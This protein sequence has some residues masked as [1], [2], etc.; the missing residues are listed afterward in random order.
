VE[1]GRVEDGYVKGRYVGISCT[2]GNGRA[3]EQ[4]TL[5]SWQIMAISKK[6]LVY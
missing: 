1:W 4:Q 5:P 2:R 3:Y 6:G